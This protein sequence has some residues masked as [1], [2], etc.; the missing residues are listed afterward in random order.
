MECGL[1]TRTAD[2]MHSAQC[3]LVQGG[4]QLFR[5]QDSGVVGGMVSF[6]LP[7]RHSTAQHTE[8]P[9]RQHPEAEV[10][11]PP[12]SWVALVAPGS[13]GTYTIISCRHHTTRLPAALSTH[14]TPTSGVTHLHCLGTSSALVLTPRCVTR[15]YIHLGRRTTLHRRPC[16]S[17]GARPSR[18]KTVTQNALWVLA[19]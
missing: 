9:L 5:S 1:R 10:P 11:L 13:N 17:A 18:K 16:S 8:R 12:L 4:G 7:A 19:D 6:L 15:P 3:S 2:S 14:P